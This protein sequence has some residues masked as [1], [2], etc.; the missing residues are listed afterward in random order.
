MAEAA[1]ARGGLAAPLWWQGGV[2]Y[3]IYPR[4]FQ[5][6]NG[7]GIG[8]LRGITSRLDHLND[9]SERSLGIDAI[10]LSPTFPSPMKDFGYDV[11]DYCDVHPDFGDLAAMDELIAACHARGIRLLLDYVPNH[12]SD[13]HP[14]FLES[15]SSRDSPKRGWY[16]WRDPAPG[17]GPPNNWLSAFGGGAW[18][19]D[20]RTGQYYLH[21]FLKEQPDLNWRNPEVVAAMHD[22]LRFWLRRGIDGFRIDALGRAL[23]D[24]QMRDNPPNPNWMPEA[25]LPQ[26]FAQIERYNRDW[27]DEIDVVRGIRRVLDEF[28]ERMAVGEV[29]GSP[30][31]LAWY[32]GGEALDGLNLAFNFH[33]IGGYGAPHTRW[34]AAMFRELVD[35]AQLALP[36]GAIP[37]YVMGNH[38]QPRLV[39]RYGRAAAPSAAVLLLTLPGTPFIYYGEE[40]GMEDVPIAEAQARDPA[41]HGAI[42]RDPERTPMQWSDAPGAGF[43]RGSPWLP[44]GDLR[45]NVAA[46]SDDPD[47]LLNLYRRL[48]W[49]RK[50]SPAL[51]S[52]AYVSV[53]GT[54]DGV[55]GFL[56]S[57]AEQRALT[58]VN[59]GGGPAS[60]PLPAELAGATVAIAT[61]REREGQRV[62]GGTLDLSGHEAVVLL[63]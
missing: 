17:G 41:R 58:L 36:P 4:S 43:S 53:P 45:I 44:L 29:F 19:W 8:D 42:G 39:S 21:S 5:D 49:Q 35:A 40:I 1:A 55:Y 50:R 30:E 10:W 7:D 34:D 48:I 46:Q 23:K 13:Q 9:G 38:D 52:G 26:R 14:W 25:G 6:S 63:A 54:P 15:R 22:V 31:T 60:A 24:P 11:S 62:R 12:S 18:E 3:Q 57:V 16:Y 61:R 51:R 32:L 28:P 37:A 33:L 27:P 47:S 56:R 2:I 20:E 59:F